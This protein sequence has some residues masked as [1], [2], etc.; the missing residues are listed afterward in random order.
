MAP[1]DLQ[2]LNFSRGRRA[3]GSRARG[4]GAILTGLPFLIYRGPR[5]SGG[6]HNRGRDHKKHSAPPSPPQH[7]PKLPKT[8]PRPPMPQK[9]AYDTTRQQKTLRRLPKSRPEPP[10][11]P[12]LFAALEPQTTPRPPQDRPKDTPEAKLKP[13]WLRGTSRC[14]IFHVEV[15]HA[16]VEHEEGERS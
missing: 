11:F 15:E 1:G 6:G 14:S 12:G 10:Q 4:R 16:E 7:H 2:K 9:G 5:R 8:T 3:R 13:K